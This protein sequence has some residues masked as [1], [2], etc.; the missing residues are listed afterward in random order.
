MNFKS[1][2][3]PKGLQFN[4]DHFYI[5]GKYATILTTISYPRLI[6]DGYLACKSS[7][8]TYTCP[9]FYITKNAK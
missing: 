3:A 5:S 2:I 9:F 6:A 8:K 1:Q 4:R 7:N